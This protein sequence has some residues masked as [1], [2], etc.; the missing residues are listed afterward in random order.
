MRDPQLVRFRQRVRNLCGVAQSVLWW[1]RPL[2]EALFER[3]A[4]HVFHDQKI[5][6]VLMTDV[7]EGANVRMR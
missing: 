4:F 2:D 7:M 3:F 5:N 6:A 1:Q